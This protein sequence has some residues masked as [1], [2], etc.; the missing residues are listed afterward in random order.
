MVHLLLA[1]DP[2]LSTLFVRA[3]PG[4]E[5]RL[6][7]RDKFEKTLKK[8]SQDFSAKTPYGMSTLAEVEYSIVC[9]DLRMGPFLL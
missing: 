8:L 7:V 5:L 1:F 9:S 3:P 2:R 6:K 4:Y